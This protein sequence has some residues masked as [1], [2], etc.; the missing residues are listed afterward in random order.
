[1][2]ILTPNKNHSKR[3][4]PSSG[5]NSCSAFGSSKQILSRELPETSSRTPDWLHCTSDREAS[6]DSAKTVVRKS[7]EDFERWVKWIHASGP[8]SVRMCCMDGLSTKYKRQW[9]LSTRDRPRTLVLPKVEGLLV[10]FH[11]PPY[12]LAKKN[13]KN[14][15]KKIPS[16]PTTYLK[17]IAVDTVLVCRV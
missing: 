13:E 17:L 3:P 14:S 4:S 16:L 6:L 12:V 5:T 15:T 2:C 1:M 10:S 9:S 11:L 7:L 8:A